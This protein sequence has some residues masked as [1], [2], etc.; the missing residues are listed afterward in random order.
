M[1]APRA[2]GRRV[3]F[4]SF[5][6]L[7]LARHPAVQRAARAALQRHGVSLGMPRALATVPDT[8]LLEAELARLTGQERA[9]LF[10]STT[11]TALDI[12]PALAGRAG[13]V[14]LD[15]GAYVISRQAAQAARGAG[16]QVHTFRHNDARA[17]RRLL[18]AHPAR[19]NKVIVCDG[20]YSAT[21]EQAPLRAF[22][23]LAAEFDALVY[24]DDAH[25]CG[26][27]GRGSTRQS[28][29]G[30]GGGGV[31]LHQGAPPGRIVYVGSLSKAFGVPV[32]FAA[33]TAAL[34]DRI[35]RRAVSPAHCSPPAA[36]LVAAARAAL[37]VNDAGG[38]ARRSRILA[39]AR[40][41]RDRLARRGIPTVHPAWFPILTVQARAPEAVARRLRGRGFFVIAQPAPRGKAGEAGEAAGVLRMVVRADHTPAQLTA[42]AD[43]LADAPAAAL[44]PAGPPM[45]EAKT[46]GG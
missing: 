27:L 41:L 19:A 32:A 6:Y 28:P 42:L 46:Q 24:V 44:A 45:R 9:L 17:L 25:G 43:A 36:P 29:Y 21:G 35:R 30:L 8:P 18:A 20:V 14:L 2:A 1:S 39:N 7:G 23:A 4:G 38:D 13:V 22:A 34:I 33:S 5:D 31:A 10:P 12:I 11:H 16:A 37:R 15:Q 40:G 26:I 3:N